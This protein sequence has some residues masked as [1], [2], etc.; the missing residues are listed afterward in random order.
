[1]QG[2]QWLTLAAK[3]GHA[4]AKKMADGMRTE[5]GSFNISMAANW[6]FERALAGDAASSFHLGKLYQYG[7]G[8][9]ADSNEAMKWYRRA[10]ELGFQEAGAALKSLALKTSAL[11]PEAASEASSKNNELVAMLEERGLP[12]WFAHPTLW[13]AIAGLVILFLSVF[14]RRMLRRNSTHKQEKIQEI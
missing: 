14:I 6:Y 5:L 12:L 11:K 2:K 4:V 9:E 1:V 13:I 8:V 3:H 7:W 10:N